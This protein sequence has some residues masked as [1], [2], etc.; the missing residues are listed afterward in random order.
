M[1]ASRAFVVALAL[2]AALPV[3]GAQ[4]DTTPTQSPGM[5]EFGPRESLEGQPGITYGIAVVIG[6]VAIGGLLAVMM[7]KQKPRH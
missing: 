2:L 4:N 3:V 7:F 1:R 6:T 5:D